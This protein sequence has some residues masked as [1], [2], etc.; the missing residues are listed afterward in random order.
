MAKAKGELLARE[1]G[2]AGLRRVAVELFQLLG[3]AAVREGFLQ[4]ELAVEMVLDDGLVAPGDEDDVLD[5]CGAGLVHHMLHHRAV[6][7]GEHFLRHRLRRRQE[8]GAE[9]GDRENGFP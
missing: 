4:L 1:G 5:A 8:A 2:G 9:T 3:L 7:H 6:H